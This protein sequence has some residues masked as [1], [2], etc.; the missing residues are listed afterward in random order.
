MT[1]TAVRGLAT[2][3]LPRLGPHRAKWLCQSLIDLGADVRKPTPVMVRE[4]LDALP[5]LVRSGAGRK[6]A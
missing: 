1:E 4:A 2:S 3:K 6:A 5:R